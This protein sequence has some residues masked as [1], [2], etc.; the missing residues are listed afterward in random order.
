MAP[1]T[2]EMAIDGIS[3]LEAAVLGQDLPVAIDAQLRLAAQSYG[4]GPRAERL[5]LA[6]RDQAPDHA[7]VLIA[8]YR[9]Y[10]YQGRLESCRQVALDCLAKGLADLGLAADWRQVRRDDACFGDYAAILPRFVL[11]TLKGYAYL[12]LR[13]GALAEGRAAVDKLLELDPS[14]KIGARTLLGV[15]ERQ[16][17]GHDD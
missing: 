11:F 10:F 14:D 3:A 4:D 17:A 8:L 16:E 13:L 12:C 6:A 1:A 2:L 7:A 5:L 9:F 15:I